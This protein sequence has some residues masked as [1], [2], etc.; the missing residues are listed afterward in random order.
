MDIILITK[1]LTTTIIL[2]TG[3]IFYFRV[4]GKYNIIDKPN[5]RSSHDYVTIRGGGIVFWL[6]A[7]LYCLNLSSLK[8]LT[9]L[10]GFF[11][12]GITLISAV[13][14]WDDIK[15]LPNSVRILIHF[16]SISCIFYGLEIFGIG[17]GWLIMAAYLF[18]VGVLNACNFMDG[19][20]GMTGLYSLAVLTALQIVNYQVIKFT[21]PEF[22]NYAIIACIIFL[23]FNFRKKARCFAGDIGSVGISFWIVTLLLQLMIKDRSFI[24]IFFLSVYGVDSICTI[25]HRLYLRQNIFKAHRMHFYQMLSNEWG[26]SHLKVSAMYASAQ[27]LICGLIIYFREYQVQ[28]AVTMIIILSVVYSLKFRKIKKS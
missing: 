16:V 19:I 2:F 1:Y 15:S 26:I 20:N 12:L 10:S 17:N 7:M 9:G 24:W 23:F 4:A 8:D 11:A 6:A 5:G 18:S 21:I 28:F 27:L 22:I 13:S 25:L 14:L 3:M